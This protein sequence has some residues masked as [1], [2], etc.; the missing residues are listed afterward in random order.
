[1]EEWNISFILKKDKLSLKFKIM[2][3]LNNILIHIS[4]CSPK[5][6][7]LLLIYE[8]SNGQKTS[9]PQMSLYAKTSFG[10]QNN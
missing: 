8:L 4:H 7:Y 2:E 9:K 10:G 3:L 1:M 5:F 6:M